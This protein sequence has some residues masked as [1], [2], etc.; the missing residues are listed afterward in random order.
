MRV[1]QARD[2]ALRVICAD[3]AVQFAEI[4][5]PWPN[6]KAAASAGPQQRVTGRRAPAADHPWRRY[7]A[8]EKRRAGKSALTREG[9][10]K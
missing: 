8:V 6:R 10:W 5:K 2:G 3:Q 4:P 9:L 1:E 7:P